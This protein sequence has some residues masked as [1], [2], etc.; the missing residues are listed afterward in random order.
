VPFPSPFASR[1][2]F[3]DPVLPRGSGA[4]LL[5]RRLREPV[6][7]GIPFRIAKYFVVRLSNFGAEDVTS[8]I[9][10]I[11]LQSIRHCYSSFILLFTLIFFYVSQ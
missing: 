9:T 11:I 5:R 1:S 10:D 3:F 8:R 6:C 4:P 7:N 2:Y